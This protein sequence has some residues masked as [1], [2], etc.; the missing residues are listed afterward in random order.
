MQPV[1]FARARLCDRR[2]SD[3]ANLRLTFEFVPVLANCDLL[4]G[5]NVVV[6]EARPREG[7]GG[8]G[9]GRGDR[10]GYGGR[11]GDRGGGGGGR[12]RYYLEAAARCAPRPRHNRLPGRLGRAQSPVRFWPRFRV[13]ASRRKDAG[14]VVAAF[15]T[16]PALFHEF[17]IEQ[18]VRKRI[19]NVDA[20]CP[21]RQI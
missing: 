16:S 20:Q 14:P 4:K 7:G 3:T 15:K 9:E 19:R 13:L 10:G 18:R 11:G 12:G 21:D 1:L 2:L 5:R 17:V 6:N 8:R